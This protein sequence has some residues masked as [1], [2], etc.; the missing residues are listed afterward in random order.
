MEAFEKTIKFN[1]PEQNL[2]KGGT[3]FLLPG[4]MRLDEPSIG[5]LC[6]EKGINKSKD[7]PSYL[8]KTVKK[9]DEFPVVFG[10]SYDKLKTYLQMHKKGAAIKDYGSQ[11]ILVGDEIPLELLGAVFTNFLNIPELRLWVQR[12]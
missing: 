1:N 6:R 11:G 9:F 8:Q 12:H 7:L 5:E 4:L 10:F 3:E 2:Q